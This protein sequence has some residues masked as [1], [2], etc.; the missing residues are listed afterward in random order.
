MT[1]TIKIDIESNPPV[2]YL[3]YEKY[4]YVDDYKI[5][6]VSTDESS[7]V[8]YALKQLREKGEHHTLVIYQVMESQAFYIESEDSE[9]E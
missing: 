5:G 3:V 4:Q 2:K 7:A 9:D 6:L 1:T 8:N